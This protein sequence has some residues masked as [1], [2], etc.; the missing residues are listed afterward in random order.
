MFDLAHFYDMYFLYL[1]EAKEES[2]HIA[3]MEDHKKQ[4]AKH[5]KRKE[6]LKRALKEDLSSTEPKTFMEALKLVSKLSF[7]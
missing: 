1:S 6:E 3:E 7:M 4:A 2:F 5:A